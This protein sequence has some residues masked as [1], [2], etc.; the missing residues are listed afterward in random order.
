MT[1]LILDSWAWMEYFDGSR[2]GLEV[3]RRIEEG[4]A[5]THSVTISEVISK[6]RRRGRDM[7]DARQAFAALPKVIDT[8]RSSSVKVGELHA[9]MRSDVPNFSLAD[10]FVLEAAQRLGLKVLTRDPDFKGLEEAEFLR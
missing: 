1:R 9:K 7:E 2:A 3:K 4:E 6:L 10:A 5:F 8:D